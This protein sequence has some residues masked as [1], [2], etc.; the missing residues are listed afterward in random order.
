M[1][2]VPRDEQL[3]Y[4]LTYKEKDTVPVRMIYDGTVRFWK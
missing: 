2:Y 3:A 4:N 1:L